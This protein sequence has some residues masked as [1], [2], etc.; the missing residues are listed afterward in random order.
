MSLVLR[1][2]FQTHTAR[3]G[4][5]VGWDGVKKKKSQPMTS[6]IA[7]S[8]AETAKVSWRTSRL[9]W[10]ATRVQRPLTSS[11]VVSRTRS[12]DCRSAHWPLWKGN[13]TRR[14]PA[15]QHRKS[16]LLWLLRR[17]SESFISLLNRWEMRKRCSSLLMSD[18]TIFAPKPTEAYHKKRINKKHTNFTIKIQKL[19]ASNGQT[20][21]QAEAE[22]DAQVTSHGGWQIS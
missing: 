13:D 7:S 9:P 2:C 18:W 21:R 19:C 20:W 12:D 1:H 14:A 16:C 10:G 3:D 4:V 5:G 22:P 11:L 8:A 17:K 15:T 6:L